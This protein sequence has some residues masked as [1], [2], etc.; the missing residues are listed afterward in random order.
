MKHFHFKHERDWGAW[1][2]QLVEPRTSTQV[3]ISWLM[4]LS[5]VLGSVLTAQNLD[6]VSD[7]MSPSLSA[8]PLLTLCLS[9]S[10]KETK[11]KQ[12]RNTREKKVVS[13]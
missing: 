5:P 3:M 9:H 7:S 8:L 4:G 1:V 11:I 6:H 13:R 10:Q 12:K 2:A